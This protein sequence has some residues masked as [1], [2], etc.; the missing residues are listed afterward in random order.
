MLSVPVPGPDPQKRIKELE[1]ALHAAR[2]GVEETL[3][4]LQ[5]RLEQTRED[6]ATFEK[7]SAIRQ[8]ERNEAR[9][10]RDELKVKVEELEKKLAA[11][12]AKP[13][14]KPPPTAARP[15]GPRPE[16]AEKIQAL[17]TELEQHKARASELEMALAAARGET[18]ALKAQLAQQVAAAPA[19]GSWPAG[20]DAE[21]RERLESRIAELERQVELGTAPAQDYSADE[22][23]AQLEAAL[24]EERETNSPL[25]EEAARYKERVRVL[26]KEVAEMRPR[27]P[28]TPP[29]KGREAPSDETDKLLARIAELERAVELAGTGPS[30]DGQGAGGSGDQRVAELETQLAEAREA[31]APALEELAKAKDRIRA[32]EKE[33]A[34]LRPGAPPLTMPLP[35]S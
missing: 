15:A 23:V 6:K 17:G 13:A 19:P 20:D 26:E 9:K 21:V 29:N 32:L 24:A 22:R 16:D 28:A 30:G 18:D 31:N 27:Q 2:A 3:K 12:A 8:K 4:T 7:T 14:L 1:A 5:N 10:E 25:R 34:S 11:A 33:I 35:Q